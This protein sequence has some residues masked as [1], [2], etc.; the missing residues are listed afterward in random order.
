MKIFFSLHI[1]FFSIISLAQ[2]SKIKYGLQGS[3]N[4]SQ[5]RGY[6]LPISSTFYSEQPGFAFTG[7]INIEY[8]LSAK[9]KFKSEL[10]YERKS[11]KAKNLITLTDFNGNYLPDLRYNSY[12]IFDFI[13]LPLLLKYYFSE[14]NNKSF[15]VNGGGYMG[16][17]LQSKVT[18][19]LPNTPDAIAND[20]LYKKVDF[21]VVFGIGKTFELKKGNVFVELRDNLGLQNINNFSVWSNGDKRLNSV[22]L[23]IGYNFD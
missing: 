2:S 15:Y 1:M 4:Y 16:Y 7:G 18:F 13:T 11:Q 6:T 17:L 22:N 10:N 21:G 12:E 9:L 14:N 8:F 19:D 5:F 20:E 3:L 23:I